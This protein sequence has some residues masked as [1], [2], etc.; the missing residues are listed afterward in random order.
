MVEYGKLATKSFLTHSLYAWDLFFPNLPSLKTS[1]EDI[2]HLIPQFFTKLN[3][4]ALW[5]NA[6]QEILEESEEN[7]RAG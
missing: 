6:S 1:S 2:H 7:S 3:T 5:P 4:A